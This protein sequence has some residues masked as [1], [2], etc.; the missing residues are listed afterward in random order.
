MNHMLGDH[1]IKLIQREL[2][3]YIIKVFFLLFLFLI[4]LPYATFDCTK[5]YFSTLEISLKRVEAI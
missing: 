3:L 2:T 5:Y 1:V 4:N